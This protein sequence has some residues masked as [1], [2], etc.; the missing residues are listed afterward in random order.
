MLRVSDNGRG[1]IR[2]AT[3][4]GGGEDGG[5]AR[6]DSYGLRNM[7][8]R[9]ELMGGHL[10]VASRPGLGTTVTAIIPAGP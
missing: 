7:A 3:A 8:E 10:E 4:A 6:E 5:R 1:F 2:R 9:A